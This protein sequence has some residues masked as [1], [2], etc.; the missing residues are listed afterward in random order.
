MKYTIDITVLVLHDLREDREE[1]GIANIFK[2]L[3]QNKGIGT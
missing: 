3:G 2:N 1:L